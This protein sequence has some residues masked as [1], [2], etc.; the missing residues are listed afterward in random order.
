M[1]LVASYRCERCIDCTNC[2]GCFECVQCLNVKNSRHMSFSFDC[3]GCHYCLFCY[4]LRNKFY[5]IGNQQYSQSDFEKQKKQF[6]YATQN[7]FARCS[8]FLR[9]ILLEKAF[10]R[11]QYFEKTENVHGNYLDEAKN[12]ENT[13]FMSRVEDLSNCMRGT[14]AK[15]CLDCVSSYDTE[16]M[17]ACSAVQLKCYDVRCSFQLTEARFVEYSAY[18][19]QVENC[20]GC[21]GLVKAKNCIMNTPYSSQEY[22]ILKQKLTDHMKST[23][24]WGQFFPG[25]FAPN[26]YDESWSSFYF[27][28][29]KT[30]QE[31]M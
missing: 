29:S 6:E 28:L 15:T 16:K 4:N 18:S 24:E 31:N 12:V 27:P 20:F 25:S 26:P 14:M 23:G 13:Y 19:A 9:K 10:F 7:G 8:E 22:S 11:A 5:C 2:H 3:S 17:Y 30:E 21:C 1:Y